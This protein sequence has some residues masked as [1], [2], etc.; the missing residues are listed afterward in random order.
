MAKALTT[1]LVA[2]GT[3][4]TSP[5]TSLAITLSLASSPLAASCFSAPN[6]AS[7]S[8]LTSAGAAPIASISGRSAPSSAPAERTPTFLS[9]PTMSPCTLPTRPEMLTPPLWPWP[10]PCP[11]PGSH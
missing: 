1:A 3:N 9:R 8:L 2:P 5:S 10:S 11:P 6:F 4:P 7:A